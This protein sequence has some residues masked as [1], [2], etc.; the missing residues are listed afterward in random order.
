MLAYVVV[1]LIAFSCGFFAAALLTL[2]RRSDTV[3]AGQVLAEAVDTF[4][5]GHR[6]N[7]NE[8]GEQI[9]VARSEIEGLRRALDLHDRLHSA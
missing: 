2:G 5:D 4:T 8:L 6:Q 7:R 1:A 9:P 3:R